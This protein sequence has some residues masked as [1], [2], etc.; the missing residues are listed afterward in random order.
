MRLPMICLL[1]TLGTGAQADGLAD[2]RG[3]LSR[4]NGQEAVKASVDHQSWRKV[5]DGKKS[6][7]IQGRAQ[8]QVED[9]PA[10]LKLAFPKNLLQQAAQEAQARAKDPEKTTPTWTAIGE[11]SL[12]QVV[13]W[14]NQGDALLREIE[15]GQAKVLEDRADTFQGKPARLLVLQVTPRMKAEDK[16]NVKDLQISAKVWLGQDNLPMGWTSS[17]QVKASKF[18]ISF[19][20]TQSEETRFALVRNRLVATYVCKEES[21][22][23]MSMNTQSKQVTT[24]SWN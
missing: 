6:D 22:S 18:F 5:V 15:E 4:L 3:A 11:V 13:E 17:T 14:A 1:V 20:S 7:I 10:G 24:I 8:A 21:S 2:L 16:K 9:G 23:V 19:T 12:K